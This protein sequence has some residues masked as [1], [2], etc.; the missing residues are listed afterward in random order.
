[1][2]VKREL[3]LDRCLMFIT[4]A[5]PIT[6]ETVEYFYSLNI[7]LFSVYGMSENTGPFNQ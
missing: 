2:R 1:M 6:K 7:P 3:G 4:A 5:A